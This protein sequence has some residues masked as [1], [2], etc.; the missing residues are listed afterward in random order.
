MVTTVEETIRKVLAECAKLGV[1]VATVGVDADLYTL[2]LTSH[3]TVNVMLG[4]EDAFDVEFPD[5]ALR[6][7]TFRSIE[8]IA[9]TL[10][11]IG[12][13]TPVQPNDRPMTEQP[14]NEGEQL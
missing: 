7:D 14:S 8:S 5:S 11:G 2:G 4:L 13:P 10:R 6:R 1:D 9:A 12:E 3:A